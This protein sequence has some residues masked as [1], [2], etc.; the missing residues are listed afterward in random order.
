MVI[1][2]GPFV[3][4]TGD[5]GLHADAT[6]TLNGGVVQITN[7][8]EGIESAVITINGGEFYLLSSD[9]GINDANWQHR[10]AIK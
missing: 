3:I 7:S 9:D 6:L 10:L 8:Y 4:A 5:D 2:N 1:N